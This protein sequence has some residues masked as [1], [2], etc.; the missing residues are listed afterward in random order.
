MTA[1]IAPPPAVSGLVE[2]QCT[3]CGSW[4]GPDEIGRVGVGGPLLCWL[5]GEGEV[6]GWQRLAE[7]EPEPVVLGFAG[8]TGAEHP[9]PCGCTP[10]RTCS[11]LHQKLRDYYSEQLSAARVNLEAQRIL[12]EHV[13]EQLRGWMPGW[14]FGAG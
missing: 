3:E 4:R 1:A 11:E 14:T 7:P 9:K 2:A 12:N 6:D 8:A 10:E 13:R 5:C